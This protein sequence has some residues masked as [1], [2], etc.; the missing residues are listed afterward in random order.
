M[1]RI[2]VTIEPSELIRFLFEQLNDLPNKRKGLNK[3]YEIKEVVLAAF[4]IF[5]TQC[6][7]FSEHQY[8]MKK[9]KGKGKR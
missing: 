9:K 8:L 4:S 2:A 7:S 6:P 1:E 3:T 5:F